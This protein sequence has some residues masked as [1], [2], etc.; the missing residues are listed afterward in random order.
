MQLL[1]NAIINN[2]ENN[3]RLLSSFLEIR[4]IVRKLMMFVKELVRC[5]RRLEINIP[6]Y[7]RAIK[8][9]T[10]VISDDG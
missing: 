7:V 9:H 1:V 3:Q 2:L 8:S 6:D 10:H 5:I 4:M